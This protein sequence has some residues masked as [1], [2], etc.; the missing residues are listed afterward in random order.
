[1]CKTEENYGEIWEIGQA[2]TAD[3]I[4]FCALMR[5]LSQTLKGMEKLNELTLVKY[6]WFIN[7]LKELLDYIKTQTAVS[8]HKLIST[9]FH[10]SKVCGIVKVIYNLSQ[11]H[12]EF[13]F[14]F[15][16][17]EYPSIL[18]DLVLLVQQ[19]ILNEVEKHSIENKAIN[20]TDKNRFGEAISNIISIIFSFSQ[21]IMNNHRENE[22]PTALYL[23]VKPVLNQLKPF[24]YSQSDF[25]KR[26]IAMA[27][28]SLCECNLNFQMSSNNS[29]INLRSEMDKP[30]ETIQFLA[31]RLYK[32]DLD[33]FMDQ[34]K[35]EDIDCNKI[36]GMSNLKMFRISNGCRQ[37][38]KRQTEQE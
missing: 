28:N 10:V 21:Y 22:C 18:S 32:I 23:Y 9:I 34:T 12:I 31:K 2:L 33:E 17:N 20:Q 16:E 3:K 7:Y 29:E 30:S 11:D 27:I 1:M 15:I 38:F 8:P 24:L 5:L 13:F 25:V 19:T 14:Y 4:I 37:G 36:S 26:T 35:F 6:R